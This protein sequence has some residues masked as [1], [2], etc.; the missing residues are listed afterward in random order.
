MKRKI[1]CDELVFEIGDN[2][3][4]DARV[5]FSPHGNSYGVMDKKEAVQFADWAE[6]TLIPYLRKFAKEKS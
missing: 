2:L 6:K 1:E 4:G 5:F 3:A